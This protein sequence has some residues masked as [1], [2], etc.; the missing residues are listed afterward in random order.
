MSERCARAAAVLAALAMAGCGSGSSA[1]TTV[2]SRTSASSTRTAPP[3]TPAGT[4]PAPAGL[5][6]TAGYGTYE[7]CSGTC[8][9]SVPASIRR[10]LHLPRLS[11]GACPVTTGG[12]PV[13]PAPAMRLA[14]ERLIGSSWLG[15]RVTWTASPRYTG[16]VLIRG[17]RLGGSGAVGFGEGRV[18]YDELQ[19]HSTGQG[20][21]PG[22]AGGRAWLS[23][24]R[25]KS[26]GCYAYQID[27]TSFSTVMVFRVGS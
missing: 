17:R 4:P 19:L 14:S 22:P 2:A 1:S 24:T 11:R 7:L 16:P 8:A 13:T 5:A 21:A 10:Q 6:R 18:P 3:P 23:F 15:A 9:G 20:A 25:I 26:P 12:G 27:G